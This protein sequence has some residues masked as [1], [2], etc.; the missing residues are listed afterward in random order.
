MNK[1]VAYT[2]TVGAGGSYG[3]D[4]NASSITG[5]D[6]TDVTT[7]GGGKGGGGSAGTNNQ[8]FCWRFRGWS[9][10]LSMESGPG[11]GGAGTNSK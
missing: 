10:W 9:W 1:G 7:V 2:I 5:S 11:A 8:G 6:I 4:G 3:G